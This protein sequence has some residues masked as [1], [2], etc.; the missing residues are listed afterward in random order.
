MNTL[1]KR[2]KECREEKNWS[3]EDLAAAAN[4]GQSLIGNLESGNQNSSASIP[5]MAHALGVNAYWLKTG[6]GQKTSGPDLNGLEDQLLQMYRLLPEDFQAALLQDAN[7]YVVLSRPEPS[8]A[9]PFNGKAP[10]IAPPIDDTEKLAK[11]LIRKQ[12]SGRHKTL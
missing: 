2:L 5:E 6:K 8:P 12:A 9:N 4:V 11:G 3:Q 10:Q 7:K 1:A